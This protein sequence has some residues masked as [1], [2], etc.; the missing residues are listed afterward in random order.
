MTWIYMFIQI[1]G[2]TF[3]WTSCIFIANGKPQLKKSNLSYYDLF[4][5]VNFEK[6]YNSVKKESRFILIPNAKIFLFNSLIIE[7]YLK[8]I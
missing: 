1:K 2:Y 3:W 8:Y 4:H 6:K 5:M 7:N